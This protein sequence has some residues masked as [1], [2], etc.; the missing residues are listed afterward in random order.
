VL[1][2]L[3]LD[4]LLDYMGDERIKDNQQLH[5]L[6]RMCSDLLLCFAFGGVEKHRFWVV[7]KNTFLLQASPCGS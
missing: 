5:G 6:P 3:V 2:V 1:I 4:A 7:L